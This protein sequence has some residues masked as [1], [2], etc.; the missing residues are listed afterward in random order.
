MVLVR[1]SLEAD[2]DRLGDRW[3]NSTQLNFEASPSPVHLVLNPGSS[4]LQQ[5]R[6]Y[7][8]FDRAVFT[9]SEMHPK[10]DWQTIVA[11]KQ[12]E[13]QQKLPKDWLLPASIKEMLK[14]PLEQHPNNVIEMDIPRQSKI[15]ND[16]ELNITEDYTVASLL[17]QL[18]SGKLSALEV[19]TAFS[20]RAAI[21]GQLVGRL[22]VI[23]LHSY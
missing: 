12:K 2:C 13:C 21:A 1:I 6:K 18:A 3:M 5:Y 9:H 8:K 22:Q 14:W 19:T 11:R 20:K 16:R 4:S 10:E 15:M 17:D 23:K 7:I